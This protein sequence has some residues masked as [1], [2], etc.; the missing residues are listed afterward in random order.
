MPI[1]AKSLTPEQLNAPEITPEEVMKFTEPTDGFLCS[2]KAVANSGIQFTDIKIRDMSP[3]QDE[4]KVYVEA[5]AGK[6]LAGEVR[7]DPD[8]PEERIMMYRLENVLD[9]EKIS[10]CI[11]FANN[12]EKP[13]ENFRMIEKYYFRNKLIKEYDFTFGFVIPQSS[14][15]HEVIYDPPQVSDEEKDE[16]LKNPYEVYCD[17]FYFGGGKLI[18]HNKARYDYA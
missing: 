4:P 12:G 16:I 13:V 8:C 10:V 14:N 2:L 9:A 3:G 17:S 7:K 1:S 5:R 11:T 18:L 15:T 6:L